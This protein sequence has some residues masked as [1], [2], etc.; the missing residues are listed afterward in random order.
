MQYEG[1][2][3]GRGKNKRHRKKE[4]RREI[5]RF[6]FVFL[7]LSEGWRVE[8]ER[9]EKEKEGKEEKEEEEED[10]GSIALYGHLE[11][12]APAVKGG[13]AEVGGPMRRQKLLLK[14]PLSAPLAMVMT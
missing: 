14:C 7:F 1:D 8:R 4:A 6:D 3:E 12:N 10:R 13:I 11:T 9:G 2:W 5:A